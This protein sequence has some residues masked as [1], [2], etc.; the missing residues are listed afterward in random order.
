ML[1]GPWGVA[2]YCCP[3]HSWHFQIKLKGLCEARLFTKRFLLLSK[4]I[5][6]CAGWNSSWGVWGR[7][8]LVTIATGPGLG[9]LAQEGGLASA[10]QPLGEPPPPQSPPR[11]LPVT[12]FSL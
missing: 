3:P 11:P 8:V 6:V 2:G 1:W 4:W 9:S 5:H 12:F 10:A 7:F